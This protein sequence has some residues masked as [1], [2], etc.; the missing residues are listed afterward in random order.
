MNPMH[1]VSRWNSLHL[2]PGLLLAG[3]LALAVPRASAQT[4]PRPVEP[5]NDLAPQLEKLAA[6][7]KEVEAQL[8]HLQETE[9]KQAARI[10]AE[11]EA[12]EKYMRAVAENFLNAVIAHD[13]P[14]VVVLLSKDFKAA[15][16]PG[17]E[18]EA[19]TA[20]FNWAFT[21]NNPAV[22]KS[23]SIETEI[24]APGKDEVAYRGKLAGDQ[25]AT[26]N[27]IVVKDKA[28]GRYL[29]SFFLL[30]AEK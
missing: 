14:A 22:Y 15:I 12:A 16:A 27:L 11:G 7:L 19:A 29:V 2:W 18:K 26:F 23:C 21:L 1:F 28:S 24:A 6:Q 17:S 20:V 30:K 9:N 4:V 5:G 8:R 13:T 25:K 3:C 10:K